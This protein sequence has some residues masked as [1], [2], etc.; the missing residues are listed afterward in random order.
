ML[1]QSLCTYAH[2]LIPKSLST[3][4]EYDILLEIVEVK[5]NCFVDVTCREDEIRRDDLRSVDV[6]SASCSYSIVHQRQVCSRIV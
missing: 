5:W 3:S 2:Q 1:L 6:V 4:V